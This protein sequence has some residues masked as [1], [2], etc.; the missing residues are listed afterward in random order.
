MQGV[1]KH[2]EAVGHGLQPTWKGTSG[3]AANAA[4]LRF[5]EAAVQQVKELTDI[6]H[7]IQSAGVQYTTADEDHA[8]TLASKM[9]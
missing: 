3:S 2:V 5:Q 7:N 8:S 6:S 1:I 9:L 4:L